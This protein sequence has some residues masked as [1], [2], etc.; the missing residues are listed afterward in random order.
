MNRFYSSLSKHL[1]FRNF[2]Y[3][4]IYIMLAVPEKSVDIFLW[5]LHG[6]TIS[7]KN[8]LYPIKNKFKMTT[9]YSPAFKSLDGTLLDSFNLHDPISKTLKNPV[10]TGPFESDPQLIYGVCP[11]IP[12]FTTDRGESISFFPPML[13]YVKP[14]EVLNWRYY[15]GLYHITA[16]LRDHRCG[17][18]SLRQVF[19]YDDLLRKW[20]GDKKTYSILFS[21]IYEYAQREGIDTRNCIAGLYT[22]R[23]FSAYQAEYQG[24]DIT[25]LI[26]KLRS[27]KHLADI[28]DTYRPIPGKKLTILQLDYDP[29]VLPIGWSPLATLTYQGC[30]M[31][32]LAF[33]GILPQSTARE[34]TTCLPKTG[35]SI[36]S[37]IKYIDKYKEEK[38]V[39][40]DDPSEYI[41]Y[42]FPI[43]EGLARIF[44]FI[45]SQVTPSPISIPNKFII[46]KLYDT[47]YHNSELSQVGHI[48]SFRT[49]TTVRNGIS[50]AHLFFVDPQAQINYFIQD[51]FAFSFDVAYGRPTP[52]RYMD[53]VFE[54]VSESDPIQYVMD[55]L[56]EP[57]RLIVNPPPAP[58]DAPTLGGLRN[59]RKNRKTKKNKTK[60]KK[61]KTKTKKNKTK[62]SKRK[63]TGGAKTET[64]TETEA[65]TG[66]TFIDLMNKIDT[67]SNTE[68]ALADVEFK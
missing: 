40:L 26:P 39:L 9:F 55:P 11:T 57:G 53:I 18:T 46:I 31:N 20:G 65:N 45:R 5:V 51:I 6:D 38:A 67:E 17:I 8:N 36:F 23:D 32:V 4:Y 7:G 21:D 12:A 24:N 64:E 61:N 48:V 15:F 43:A 68:S 28:L 66:D 3:I 22:C 50:S 52:W 14:N 27:N 42:R 25:S 47:L 30:G 44:E 37:I 63:L 58:T 41:V 49:E 2:I 19:N 60:M 13:F 34:M 1:R 59:Y 35:S 29:T 33:Y 56:T 54:Y 10:V 16:V 62:N